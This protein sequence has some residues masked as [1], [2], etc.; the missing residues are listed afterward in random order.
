MEGSS[1]GVVQAV[2]QA[3]LSS[4]KTDIKKRSSS[5]LVAP[6]RA[7]VPPLRDYLTCI[8]VNKCSDAVCVTVRHIGFGFGS[9]SS[10]VC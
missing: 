6:D 9:V 1:F 8:Y 3:R 5:G 7:L 2:V 4:T 10:I